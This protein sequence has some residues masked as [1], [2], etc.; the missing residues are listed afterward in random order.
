[1][2]PNVENICFSYANRLSCWHAGNTQNYNSMA[3]TN[4]ISPQSHLMSSSS[5]GQARTGLAS[6]P[7]YLAT[8]QEEAWDANYPFRNNEPND[9]RSTVRNRS[10]SSAAALQQVDRSM[11]QRGNSSDTFSRSISIWKGEYGGMSPNTYASRNAFRE[12]SPPFTSGLSQSQ[13]HAQSQWERGRRG[14]YNGP[15]FDT[16]SEEEDLRELGGAGTESRRHSIAADPA[17]TTLIGQRRAIGFEVGRPHPSSTSRTSSVGRPGGLPANDLKP[18]S[19]GGLAITEDDLSFDLHNLNLDFN[20][21]DI[22]RQ[23]QE[24]RRRINARIPSTNAAVTGAHAS[25]VPMAFNGKEFSPPMKESKWPI[26]AGF[27]DDDIKTSWSDMVSSPGTNSSI[28]D[29]FLQAQS[30]Q[31]DRKKALSATAKVFQGSSALNFGTTTSNGTSVQS[32]AFNQKPFTGS[33]FNASRQPQLEKSP[34]I[35]TSS[36]PSKAFPTFDRPI[37]NL[38]QQS[39]LSDTAIASLVTLGPLA[40]SSSG[41]SDTQSGGNNLQELGKGVPLQMLPRSTTLYIVEFKEG[42]TDLY[43]RQQ[44]GPQEEIRKG[45]LVIVEADRGKDLGTV[46]NDSITVDQVQSFLSHQAELSQP[47]NGQHQQQSHI[48]NGEAAVPHPA[49]VALS[50]MSR[51]IN[52]KRLFSKASPGDTTLLHAKAQD[53]ERALALCTTKVNQRGLPMTVVAAELQWDRR[54]LTFYVS[55]MREKKL[56]KIVLIECLFSTPHRSE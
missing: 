29:P 24:D 17:S 13:S 52:P 36:P 49:A 21:I 2:R 28:Q 9:L 23:Q 34:P 6:S 25:S 43:F 27:R 22:H 7:P 15:V 40:P 14:D 45:D 12:D 53:E 54:K 48:N 38:Q 50:R 51:S 41:Q 42:R 47:S 20:G 56:P 1:V 8:M 55:L 37:N 33:A 11:A 19:G 44:Q 30:Q 10:T 26:S 31:D 5:S 4:N 32:Q 46:V 35:G 18:F 39:T 3:P 16:F